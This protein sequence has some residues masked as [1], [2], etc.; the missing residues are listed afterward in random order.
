MTL[1]QALAM[2]S[3]LKTNPMFFCPSLVALEFRKV[4]RNQS[5]LKD[6]MQFPRTQNALK[7]APLAKDAK[8]NEEQFRA[9]MAAISLRLEPPLVLRTVCI[10]LAQ[11]AAGQTSKRPDFKPSFDVGPRGP[12]QANPKAFLRPTRPS[13]AP[14]GLRLAD[15]PKEVIMTENF[16]RPTPPRWRPSGPV[17]SEL[18]IKKKP[19][20]TPSTFLCNGS[21]MNQ[22]DLSKTILECEE[23]DLQRLK[24]QEMLALR[25]GLSTPSSSVQSQ[26]HQRPQSGN[27]SS[28]GIQRLE[29]KA[30]EDYSRMLSINDDIS[31]HHSICSWIDQSN[32]RD[33][34]SSPQPGKDVEIEFLGGRVIRGGASR[35]PQHLVRTAPKQAGRHKRFCPDPVYEDAPV[36]HS[37]LDNQRMASSTPRRGETILRQAHE[38]ADKCK[39]ESIAAKKRITTRLGGVQP[40]CEA[41]NWYMRSPGI[42]ATSYPGTCTWAN[43]QVRYLCLV[44][45]VYCIPQHHLPQTT[46]QTENAEDACTLCQ[47]EHGYRGELLDGMLLRFKILEEARSRWPA[48]TGTSQDYAKWETRQ[49]L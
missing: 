9:M 10:S 43:A 13:T 14:R 22:A 23:S 45:S 24:E 35:L 42:A 25:V 27:R 21:K 1:D 36:L 33:V 41:G 12:H 46:A 6:R 18:A 28:P 37:R 8:L 11:Y 16:L 20:L 15:R 38:M 34:E 40:F 39:A 49:E 31:L 17:D 2:I 19:C 44:P 32:T 47:L 3:G 30:R 29:D 5:P 26:G 48:G 4:I 7:D